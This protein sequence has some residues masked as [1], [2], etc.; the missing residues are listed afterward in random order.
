MAIGLPFMIYIKNRYNIYKCGC[1]RKPTKSKIDEFKE[2]I[3]H[4]LSDGVD[5]SNGNQEFDSVF[6]EILL[7][8]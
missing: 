4:K 3:M 8:E 1:I 2:K 6:D 7:N 5:E